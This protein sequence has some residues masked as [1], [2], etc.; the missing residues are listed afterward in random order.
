MADAAWDTDF[1]I[2]SE[3]SAG[4]TGTRRKAEAAGTQTSTVRRAETAG[5]NFPDLIRGIV[6]RREELHF[7]FRKENGNCRAERYGYENRNRI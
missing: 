4:E 3:A 1:L 2:M 5:R 6:K 7:L